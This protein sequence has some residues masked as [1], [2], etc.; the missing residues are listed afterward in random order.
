VVNI[1]VELQF[2]VPAGQVVC[3]DDAE[4]LDFSLVL[5]AEDLFVEAVNL[6]GLNDERVDDFGQEYHQE[7]HQDLYPRQRVKHM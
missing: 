1:I 3:S 2:L 7:C 5:L 4:G 6:V